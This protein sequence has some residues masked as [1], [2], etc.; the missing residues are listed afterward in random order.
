MGLLVVMIGFRGF[1]GSATKFN[2]GLPSTI[3][4]ACACRINRDRMVR[5]FECAERKQ[6]VAAV[7]SESQK[8]VS[9]V[10]DDSGRPRTM[11][12]S[13]GTL[14]ALS[15]SSPDPESSPWRQIISEPCLF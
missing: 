6:P 8:P 12:V 11:G 3:S 15:V 9:R 7:S 14:V 2:L 10:M 4:E 1:A 13:T 5:G